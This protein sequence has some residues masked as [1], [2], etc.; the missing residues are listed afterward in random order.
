MLSQI[1]SNSFVKYS[2]TTSHHSLDFALKSFILLF[3]LINVYYYN[4][5][6]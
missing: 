5:C 1:L 3:V 2:S 4:I 6:S